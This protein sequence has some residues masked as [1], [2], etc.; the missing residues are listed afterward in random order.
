MDN[1]SEK[2][3]DVFEYVLKEETDYKT[4]K[5]PLASNWDW[6]MYDHIDR[7]VH[8]KNSQYLKGANDF[9]RPVNNIIIPIANVNYRSEGFDVKDVILYVEDKD[10]FHL[11]LLAKKFH[12]RW[13]LK[14]SIDT[15][16]DETVESYFDY[17]LSLL[18]NINESRPEVVPLQSIAFCDQTDILAGPICLK[19]Q[20]SISELEDM[21]EFWDADA[22]DKAI[23]MSSTTQER[24]K[25][26]ETKTPSKYIEVYELHI[27]A[28]ESWLN[29]DGE[30]ED[31]GKY[32]KQLQIITYYYD[33]KEQKQGIT[34][35]S[36]KE[37]KQIFKAIKRDPIFGRACG[38]G[39]IE[40]LFHPQIWTNYSEIHLQQMVEAT[41]KVVTKTTDKKLAK[42]N[43]LGNIKHGTIVAVE[44][45]KSWE[46]LILQPINKLAFDGLI[47]KWEQI[48]RTTGSASDPQLGLNPVSGTPLGTT[49]IVTNQGIGIHDYR[50]GKLATF[51]GEIYRDWVLQYITEEI[52]KGDIWVDELSLDE[53]MEVAERTATKVSNKKVVDKI[54]SG[55]MVSPQE[56]DLLRQI[57]KD[58]FMKGGRQRFLEILKGE[59]KN[60]PLQ[61]KFS[62]AG[63]QKNMAEM[64]SKLNSVFRT[65]FANPAILQMPGM[66]ELFNDILEQSGLSPVDYSKLTTPAEQTGQPTDPS[67]APAQPS[68]LALQSNNAI[69]SQ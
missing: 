52:N 60:I 6:S 23:L 2:Y 43:K 25:D 11:S 69:I 50:K 57:V 66:G 3:P 28:P 38:R 51:W 45:G 8:L 44:E 14:Y 40:E 5:I 41:S 36:G 39:G 37:P 47:N 54:L 13:A 31:T 34:L 4:R 17:G 61:V 18:K 33:N 32:V 1:P 67:Q 27:T 62:I 9:S 12:E 58:E 42:N 63:K 21:K 65:V 22:I 59:F 53:L 19:H 7:S 46:Q 68:N 35:Y 64:V 10:N 15:A 20:Y 48:A 55:V 16:I 30:K 24:V 49:E 26:K 29:T 56:R